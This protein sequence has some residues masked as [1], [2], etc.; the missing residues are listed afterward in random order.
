MRHCEEAG[1]KRQCQLCEEAGGQPEWDHKCTPMPH[2][3]RVCR[4]GQRPEGRVRGVLV[5]HL[6]PA[7]LNHIA[8]MWPKASMIEQ[9]WP[10]A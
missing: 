7:F 6:R 10:K 8:M 2:A 3:V 4:T 5:D 9:M 1:C